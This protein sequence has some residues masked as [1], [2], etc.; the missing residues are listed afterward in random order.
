[1]KY[2][3]KDPH[4]R[5]FQIYTVIDE[6][7]YWLIASGDGLYRVRYQKTPGRPIPEKGMTARIYG[8]GAGDE[9]GLFVNRRKVTYR[10]PQGQ[11]EWIKRTTLT[12]PLRVVASNKPSNS[13]RPT[14]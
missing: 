4:Y 7:N 8:R 10:S 14:R 6:G 3:R 12:H 9:R 11:Q 2:P 1:M 5:R 13:I